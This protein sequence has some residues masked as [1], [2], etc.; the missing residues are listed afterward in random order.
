[1]VELAQPVARAGNSGQNPHMTASTS[2][3]SV[4]IAG[5]YET[6][7]FLAERV[8]SFITEGL[9]AG[10]Q[11]IVL[12]TAAHWA[13][14][15]ARLND[16]GLQFQRAVTEGR[17]LLLDATEVLDGLTI[18]GRV[19]VEGFRAALARFIAPG[20]RQRIY[21]ELVSL[22]AER[23]D[24]DTALA[25]ESVGHELA[26]T[27]RMPVLCGYHAV[28]DHRLTPE[29]IGR[30][31]AIHD[32]SWSEDTLQI[33]SDAR[34]HEAV[35]AAARVH[36][37]RFYESRESLARIVGKFLGEGF[38]AGL[39]AVVIATPHHREAIT[40]VLA[41][42][43]FDLSRL[44]AANDLIMVD[45]V[46]M[47]SRFMHHGMP[48]ATRFSDAMIPVIEQACRGRKDC[49]IRAY[50]EMV[51]VLWQAGQ[52]AAA[53][54]LEML[55]NQLAQT[56]SFALLCGYSMGHFYKDV[57]QHEILHQHTHLV[58]DSGECATLH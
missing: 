14:I 15:S 41:G 31:A 16:S 43:Y 58:S 33:A 5:F 28:G 56:H 36:A 23:G 21:G 40:T 10:E 20:V 19:S 8:A 54:R 24:V 3:P 2:P 38:I 29:A 49:V 22:L 13:A 17:L 1:M 52:T 11:V 9:T 27:L 35:A 37:V 45:A 32:R 42:H 48:D 47:L 46:E 34:D 18:D 57:G 44:E 51:D 30:I 50:G 12:A 7:G 55:W 25:I 26:H 4:H 6:D 39:P 53:I